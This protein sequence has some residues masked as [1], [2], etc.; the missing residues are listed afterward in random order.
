MPCR[1]FPKCPAYSADPDAA[2]MNATVRRSAGMLRTRNS[3]IS[4]VS[5]KENSPPPMRT[6]SCAGTASSTRSAV[7]DASYFGSELALRTTRARSG[8][9]MRR[10][11]PRQPRVLAPPENARARQRDF[12]KKSRQ[13]GGSVGRF[14]NPQRQLIR[15][16]SVVQNEAVAGVQFDQ[17]RL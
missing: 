3:S 15:Y 5:P 8:D 13:E 4:R 1:Y 6:S 17:R 7:T 16:F 9:L 14:R 12:T 2:G 11:V 10:D